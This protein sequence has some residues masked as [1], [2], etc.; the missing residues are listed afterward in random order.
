MCVRLGQWLFLGVG[1][2]RD[3]Q[4]RCQ[5]GVGVVAVAAPKKSDRDPVVLA[6]VE[7]LR[8]PGV[9]ELG[10]SFLHWFRATGP[11]AWHDSA[12]RPS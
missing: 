8:R 9:G 5:V 10:H 11:H 1:S 2:R 7:L 6:A 3:A 4:L 12:S